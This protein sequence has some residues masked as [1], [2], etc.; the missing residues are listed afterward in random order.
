MISIGIGRHDEN[1][2][3]ACPSMR[4]IA[5]QGLAEHD[6]RL[7]AIMKADG[8]SDYYVVRRVP[9]DFPIAFIPVSNWYIVVV[10]MMGATTSTVQ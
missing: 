1:N 5:Q 10:K 4:K 8:F 6:C 7:Q 3:A 9:E 2:K